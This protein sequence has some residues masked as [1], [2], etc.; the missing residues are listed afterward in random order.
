M[1]CSRCTETSKSPCIIQ[2]KEHS[3]WNPKEFYS[4]LNSCWEAAERPEASAAQ[5]SVDHTP[6]IS[7]RLGCQ[8]L[9]SWGPH[10]WTRLLNS[11]LTLP[12]AP[13]WN[14]LSHAVCNPALSVRLPLPLSSSLY[15]LRAGSPLTELTPFFLCGCEDKE[16]CCTAWSYTEC[17]L[18]LSI[19]K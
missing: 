5:S 2:N 6:Q 16:G 12:T 1:D 11:C 13:H 3:M 15:H 4:L 18:G 9:C 10:T 7:G 8:L 17:G 19:G 14:S